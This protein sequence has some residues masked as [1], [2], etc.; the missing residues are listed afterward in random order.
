MA[1]VKAAPSAEQQKIIDANKAAQA[2]AAARKA[3]TDA[4]KAAVLDRAEK[5]S[6]DFMKSDFAPLFL[7]FKDRDGKFVTAL[8]IGAKEDYK[9]TDLGEIVVDK[10]TREAVPTYALTVHVFSGASVPFQTTYDFDANALP[11][12]VAPSK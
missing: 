4:M 6:A 9:R 12:P 1:D 8:V 10:V 3:A 7:P 11:V 2:A 5:A